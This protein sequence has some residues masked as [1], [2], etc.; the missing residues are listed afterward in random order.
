MVEKTKILH[1]LTR[2]S[3]APPDIKIAV[4]EVVWAINN[5]KLANKIRDRST[6]PTNRSPPH[7]SGVTASLYKLPT[8]ADMGIQTTLESR[9]GDVRRAPKSITSEGKGAGKQKEPHSPPP[10]APSYASV[11]AV[12]QGT[13]TED[14]DWEAIMPKKKKKAKPS[15]QP[16]IATPCSAGEPQMASTP[17]R[18]PKLRRKRTEAVVPDSQGKSYVDLY[19]LVTEKMG[20]EVD[21]LTKAR[22]KCRK[23][24]SESEVATEWEG[25]QEDSRRKRKIRKIIYDS[26]DER[27]VQMKY[28]LPPKKPLC[29]WYLNKFHLY[30]FIM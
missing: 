30:Y 4:T 8:K 9:S 5:L 22:E 3:V 26:N 16:Q 6:D 25:E 21:D 2:S 7:N 1:Q 29:Y 15:S 24:E 28:P 18:P 19:R 20:R 13:S 12:T 11:A 14:M 10:P 23:A 27:Q 17:T